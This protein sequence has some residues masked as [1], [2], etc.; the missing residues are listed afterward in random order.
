M[1]TSTACE[2]QPFVPYARKAKQGVFT[3]VIPLMLCIP[4]SGGA[5][6]PHGADQLGK[7]LNTTNMNIRVEHRSSR[8]IDALSTSEQVSRIRELF[9][10]TMSDLANVF[11]VSRPTVYAW[12]RGQ[13][14]KPESLT[15]IYRLSAV[16][17]EIEKLAV[18]R[19]EKLVRRPIFQ[20]RSLIDKMKSGDDVFEHLATIKSL[21]EKEKQVRQRQ[22]GSGRSKRSIADVGAEISTPGYERS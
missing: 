7:W 9:G 6:T 4:G 18:P 13:D 11:G 20:G 17:D 10:L 19:I 5:M 14:P 21:G 8:K 22:K 15:L 12:L 1:Q 16:A 2:F 3:V